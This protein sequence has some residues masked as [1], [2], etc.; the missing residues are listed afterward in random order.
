MN[1]E[2]TI[3]L[4]DIDGTLTAPRE[5]ATDEMKSTL[6]KLRQQVTIGTVG[7]SDLCKAEEQM[8]STLLQDFDK[9]FAENGLVAFDQ[10][11]LIG[12]QSIANYLGEEKLQELINYA[13]RYMSNI[14]LPK[15]RGCFVESRA[16]MINF[17]PVGRSC[18]HEDR[19]EFYEYDK[20]HGIRDKFVQAMRQDLAHLDL[21]FSIGGEISIDVYPRGWSKVYCLRYLDNFQNVLFFGDNIKRDEESGREGNDY[22]LGIHPRVRAFKVNSPQDTLRILNELFVL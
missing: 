18:T 6:A 13:L 7:G 14:T 2:N 16:G 11:K 21:E 15:K 4:F 9:I 20:I 1:H 22:Q 8:G 12:K 5:K 17:S 10:G 19:K 3:V